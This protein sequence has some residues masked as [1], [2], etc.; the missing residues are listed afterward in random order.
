MRQ[1]KEI[2]IA[3]KKL[4]P[5]AKILE[6]QAKDKSTKTDKKAKFKFLKI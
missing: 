1:A 6:T 3:Y 5:E 2:I 4:N